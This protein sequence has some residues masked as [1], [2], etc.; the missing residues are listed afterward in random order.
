MEVWRAAA[1]RE[2]AE[3]CDVVARA[4][5]CTSRFDADAWTSP[6]RTPPGYPDAV[7]LLPTLDVGALLARI[8]TSAGC[9]VKDSF[10]SLDLSAQGFRVL[11]EAEW[12]V[13]AGPS[14]TPSAADHGWEQVQ[15]EA[16][17]VAWGRAWRGAYEPTGLFT[18]AL[19]DDETV[20]VSGA[21]RGDGFDAGAILHRSAAVVGVSNVFGDAAPAWAGCL[22]LA[23]SHFPAI[24]LVGYERD[25]EL[26]EAR[27]SGFEPAG[28]LR[29][30][31]RDD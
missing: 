12:I 2:N 21:R 8:D 6:T 17:L 16:D 24:P 4:H 27:R 19:L 3:W 15:D 31:I 14:P 26:A 23:A 13:H 1:A 28:P 25:D 18:A 11:F 29:V 22:A 7:T 20:V 5:G 10:S 9:S 30:W